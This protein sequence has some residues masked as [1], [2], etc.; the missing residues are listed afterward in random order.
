MLFMVIQ[1]GCQSRFY[2]STWSTIAVKERQRFRFSRGT[3]RRKDGKMEGRKQR[4][5]SFYII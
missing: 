5:P 4:Q 2:F 1:L 3:E